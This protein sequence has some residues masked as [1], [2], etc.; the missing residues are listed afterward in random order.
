M[1]DR[2]LLTPREAAYR[3]GVSTRHLWN[4]TNPRGPIP[5]VRLG[6]R[7][8]YRPQDLEDFVANVARLG[9]QTPRP[10][11]EGDVGDEL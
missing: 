11:Q 10:E 2:L 6:R 3:L 5:V 1:T 9:R 8:F 7:T 4:L